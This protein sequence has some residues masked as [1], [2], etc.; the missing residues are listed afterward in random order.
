MEPGEVS[1]EVWIRLQASVDADWAFLGTSSLR[2][3]CIVLELSDMIHGLI[4]QIID[5]VEGFVGH[6]VLAG[7]RG[8]A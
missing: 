8:L 5:I 7:R 6:G 4:I 3:D 1:S 2:L